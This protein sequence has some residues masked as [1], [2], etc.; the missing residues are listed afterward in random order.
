[1]LN[2]IIRSSLRQRW[3]VLGAAA[4]LMLIGGLLVARMPVDI[5]PDLTA[6]TVTVIAEARGMGP[7]EVELLIS[8]P[9]ESALN[10]AP[11]VRRLR[12]YSAAGIVV[13]RVDFEWGTNIYRARQVV[14]ER[15][16][17]V[18][19]PAGVTRPELGP[20][21][22]VMGQIAFVALTSETVDPME[23]RGLSETLVRRS[24]L[25]VPG[26]SQVVVIGGDR[27]Q[28]LVE[29]DP[30]ALAQTGVSVDALVEALES[31]SGVPAAG[32]H[33]DGGQEYLVRGRGRARSAEDLAAVVLRVENGRPLLVGHVARVREA[34]EPKRGTAAYRGESAVVLSVQK[35]PEANTLELT[36]RMDTTLANV[37]RALPEGVRIQTDTFRQAD[38]IEVAIANVAAALRDGALL[39]LVILLLFLGNLRA[40]MISA[41]AIP[42]SLVAGVL[43][44][45]AF[46]GT[47]NT[48][49]LGGF[50]I[51]IG[52]LVD[53]CA[54]STPVRRRS[55]GPTRRSSSGP[56]QKCAGRSSSPPSS[57]PWCSSRFS[58]FPGWKGACCGPWAWP[59]SRR[60]W[61]R[62][63]SP[64]R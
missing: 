52:A 62:S 33:V 61:A 24:L 16:Q 50:T 20:I 19:L 9:L 21:G 59:T 28:Y 64:S 41:V 2:A 30:A 11:S 3:V 15:L 54:K 12:S 10:G 25:A 18:A 27:R 23:L 37:Q 63:S 35:Q 45:S 51:A 44:L 39:V 53:D 60:F 32:F 31:A 17:T 4:L 36:R 55:G 8:F 56:R 13:I 5:F 29:V 48:M 1:M 34:P 14:T 46:G 40:T 43:V 47:I 6:P 42:L 49:T 57:S 26:I 22:S 38:F 58:P 7:E